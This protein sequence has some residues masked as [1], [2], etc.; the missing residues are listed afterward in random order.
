MFF[1][2]CIIHV[3]VQVCGLLN[4]IKMPPLF[5]PH[6]HLFPTRWSMLIYCIVEPQARTH[7]FWHFVEGLQE[8]GGMW[9]LPEILNGKFI[10][11]IKNSLATDY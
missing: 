6:V 3:F 5:V 8:G 9:E 1:E 7:I 2:V 10:N 11:I 4:E